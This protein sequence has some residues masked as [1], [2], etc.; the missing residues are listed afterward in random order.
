MKDAF[1]VERVSKAQGV[2]RKVLKEVASNAGS[3]GYSKAKRKKKVSKALKV[4]GQ[5]VRL[6]TLK[7][8]SSIPPHAQV[9]NH[10]AA[11]RKGKRVGTLVQFRDD[12]MVGGIGVEEGLRRKGVAT[13]MWRRAEKANWK[14]KHSP[15]RTPDGDAWAR[16]VGGPLPKNAY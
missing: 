9:E 3:Y 14:P 8:R 12:G 7:V 4:D 2:P 6:R 13:A 16:T 5:W 11:T 10:V 15:A 1:G